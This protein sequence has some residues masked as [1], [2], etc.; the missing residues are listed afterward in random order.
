MSSCVTNNVTDSQR[1]M[2]QTWDY[3]KCCIERTILVT[4]SY[5][6][7]TQPVQESHPCR[8]SIRSVNTLVPLEN[9]VENAR[10]G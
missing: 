10:M 6:Y 2:R 8:D 5:R 9:A 4:Q 3:E 7:S 1:I